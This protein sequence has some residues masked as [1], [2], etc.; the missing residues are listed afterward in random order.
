MFDE[1]RLVHATSIDFLLFTTFAP[2]WMYND[3]QKRGWEPRDVAV[4]LLALLPLLGPA[5]YLCLRPR[6]QD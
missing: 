6:A 3:A 1:S 4:P 2:F 5:A